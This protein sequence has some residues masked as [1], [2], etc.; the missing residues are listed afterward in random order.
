MSTARRFGL[1]VLDIHTFTS[2]FLANFA[3]LAVLTQLT[4]STLFRVSG[5]S[6]PGVGSRHKNR[7]RTCGRS[8][9]HPS[10]RS[11]ANRTRAAFDSFRR[12]VDSLMPRTRNYQEILHL[13]R[14][15]V[16]LELGTN[17]G[18][19]ILFFADVMRAVHSKGTPYSLLTVDV[20]PAYIDAQASSR[21]PSF[22]RRRWK[23]P[24]LRGSGFGGGIS[25]QT[26]YPGGTDTATGARE[27]GD[28]GPRIRRQG[29]ADTVAG[30]RGYGGRYGG[31]G[32]GGPRIRRQIRRAGAGGYGGRG[33][34]IRRQI[35]RIRRQGPT[36]TAADTADTAAGARGYGGGGRRHL[37]GGRGCR[38]AAPGTRV[39]AS[40]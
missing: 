29:P 3:D 4:L 24:R 17:Y 15:S 14:P 28:R 1:G 19:S 20:N 26:G 36:D 13:L 27:Y 12:V 38:P 16:L 25:R 34:R 2:T 6:Q 22:R 31:Y 7:H 9:S 39:G 18:G 35:R 10:T 33:P 30:A 40:G 21:Q 37:E 11:I 8:A 23:P 5:V 32:G